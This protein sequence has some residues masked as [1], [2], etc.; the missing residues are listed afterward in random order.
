MQIGACMGL[1]IV[2]STCPFSAFLSHNFVNYPY[3]PS[4]ITHYIYKGF[5]QY[6]SSNWP[7]L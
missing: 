5:F 1:Q 2:I 3:P 6:P 7:S 4:D